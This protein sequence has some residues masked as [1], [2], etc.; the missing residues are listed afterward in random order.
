MIS[1][2]FIGINTYFYIELKN[3][4]IYEEIIERSQTHNNYSIDICDDNW[5]YRLYNFDIWNNIGLYEFRFYFIRSNFYN[6]YWHHVN[7]N[8]LK[9]KYKKYK[10]SFK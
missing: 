6:V 5:V 4:I 9:T 2:N 3:I 1:K 8:R 7:S 10:G